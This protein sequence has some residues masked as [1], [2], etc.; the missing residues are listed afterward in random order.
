MTLLYLFDQASERQCS[1]S[2][3]RVVAPRSATQR[4][5]YQVDQI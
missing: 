1:T 3:V 5:V 2:A 4:L